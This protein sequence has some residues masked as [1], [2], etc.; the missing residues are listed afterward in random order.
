VTLPAG[1]PAGFTPKNGF[2]ALISLGA[3]DARLVFDARMSSRKMRVVSGFFFFQLLERRAGIDQLVIEDAAGNIQERKNFF[4]ANAVKNGGP[5]FARVNDVFAAQNG[6][7][8]RYTGRFDPQAVL[9]IGNVHLACAEQFQNFDSGRVGKG[10]EEIS[11]EI[12]KR[13][14]HGLYSLERKTKRI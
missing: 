5:D 7:V 2:P 13:V 4:I 6:Q 14:L 12:A 1:F 9:Q 10:F 3:V 8:L 11:F